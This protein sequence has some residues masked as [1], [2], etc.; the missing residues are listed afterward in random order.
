[1]IGQKRPSTGLGSPK[2][3]YRA[4]FN[5]C[6]GHILTIVFVLFNSRVPWKGIPHMVQEQPV[7]RLQGVQK[8]QHQEHQSMSMSRACRPTPLKVSRAEMMQE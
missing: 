6:I 8:Q 4:Y 1:M 2:P 3:L 5:S 7:V